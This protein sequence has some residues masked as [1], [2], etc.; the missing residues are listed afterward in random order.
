MTT[1]EAGPSCQ[2]DARTMG[3]VWVDVLRRADIPGRTANG[4]DLTSIMHSVGWNDLKCL[5][6]TRVSWRLGNLTWQE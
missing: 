1:V 5:A 4:V 2:P 6:T 3:N